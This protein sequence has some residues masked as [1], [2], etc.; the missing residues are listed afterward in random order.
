MFSELPTSVWLPFAVAVAVSLFTRPVM[1]A[2]SFVRAVPSYS[3]SA[4]PVVTVRAA[5]VTV[6]VPSTVST[7]V[8]L[9]VTSLPEASLMV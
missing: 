7:P 4:E 3:F 6:R 9:A 2:S 1:V 5:L 8:K